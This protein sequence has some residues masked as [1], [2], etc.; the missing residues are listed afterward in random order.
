MESRQSFNNPLLGV[1][2]GSTIVGNNGVFSPSIIISNITR[3]IPEK[4][5][6]KFMTGQSQYVYTDQLNQG[7]AGVSG[8]Y[9]VSGISKLT[10]SLSTYV[11]N[12]TA[13]SS[14]SI[15]VN[16]NVTMLSGMEYIDFDDLK[17][18]DVLNSLK[19]GPKSLALDVLNKF[20]AVR[21]KL[22]GAKSLRDYLQGDLPDETDELLQQW[23]TALQEFVKQYGDGVV[24]GV[25]W[26]GL[27]TVSMKMTSKEYE[28]NWKYGGNAEFSYSGI[29]TSVSV[30]A[31]YDGS[32]SDRESNVNVSCT[33][34]SSGGCVAEQVDKWF[35]IVANK[36]FDEIADIKLLEKAP[37]ISSVSAPPQIPDFQKPAS[38]P[39]I[40]EKLKDIDELDDVKMFSV[41]SAY[42]K[43]KA[44]DKDLT[45]EEFLRKADS[46]ADDQ[47]VKQ[48]QDE[49]KS[50][51]IDVLI[52]SDQRLKV[53]AT[54]TSIL[55]EQIPE[56]ETAAFREQVYQS[57]EDDY[58]V[59]GAWIAN[60][61][62]I[63][64]WMSTG[65][66]NEI[67]NTILAQEL[68]KKQCMVQD[69]LALSNLYYALESCNMN[70]DFCKIKSALQ[71]ANSFGQCLSVLKENLDRDNVIQ[72]TFERLSDEA[73]V[74]YKKWNEIKF[75]RSSE[76]GLGLLFNGDYSV[77]DEVIRVE[78]H[79]YSQVVYKN[80]YCSYGHGN[81]SAFSSF[82]KLL[83]MIG[84]D[85][86]IYVFGPSSMFLKTVKKDESTFTKG[87]ELAMKFHANI[88]KRI[89]ENDD[90]ILT[91]IPFS[92]ANNVHWLGQGVSTNLSTIRSVNESLEEIRKELSQLNVCTFSSDDWDKNWNYTKAYSLRAL[93]TQY[94]G[95]VDEVGNIF[96]R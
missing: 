13:S 64:P 84:A 80:G 59:L 93:K 29:G 5:V 41:A 48:L 62:N 28:D 66:L 31:S 39:E 38:E 70:L 58:T 43:A 96:G 35:E 10:S 49:V 63:F 9:G 37:N 74:I 69:L 2:I 12:S 25:I 61:S 92:A 55:D 73:K 88:E 68:L 95:M 32:K 47:N 51:N 6:G 65:Y 53:L 19:L 4:E 78:S 42:D 44:L 67:S 8:S 33:S 45:L 24:V 15:D 50:N 76:L 40:T 11:G 14:K 94:I 46:K 54:V 21:N 72:E 23:V 20:T 71:I 16:Y 90:V 52:P 60:W 1:R 79:P 17:A 83:P 34:W 30:Q 86:E 87:G 26:G 91:P 36:S 3:M 57:I 89:L 56:T 18:E 7:A 77:S 85:G 22:G 81:Y 75:L 82:L 27:G